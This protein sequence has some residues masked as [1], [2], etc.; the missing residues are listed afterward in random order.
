[1]DTIGLIDLPGSTYLYALTFVA[2]AFV[3]FSSVI[4]VLRQTIGVPLSR[5][6]VL[7]A[8]TDIELGFLVFGLA[9]LPMLLSLFNLPHSLVL[10]LSS[11]AAAI[12]LVLWLAYFVLR[13]RKATPIPPKL[14]WVHLAF[15]VSVIIVLIGNAAGYPIE[16]QVGIYALALSYVLA[17]AVD[18]FLYSTNIMIRQSKASP[19]AFDQKRTSPIRLISVSSL[20]RSACRLNER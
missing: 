8:R 1:M 19:P 3:G 15:A 11:G 4:V 2:A 20:S 12:V 14:A 5:F 6:Q 10:R 7:L 13:H 16:P 18:T 9:L 17:E